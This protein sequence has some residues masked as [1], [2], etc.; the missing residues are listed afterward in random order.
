M[1]FLEFA[2]AVTAIG[3]GTGVIIST[4]DK[5]FGARHQKPVEAERPSK[6]QTANRQRQLESEVASLRRQ[7]ELL[8]KEL[9]WH[10]RLLEQGQQGQQ[11]LQSQPGEYGRRTPLPGRR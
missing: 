3:C 2:T 6:D 9:D 4:V 7:N 5:M 8:Q 1:R 10:A 11:G